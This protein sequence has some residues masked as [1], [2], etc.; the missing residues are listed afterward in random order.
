MA[1]DEIA[2]FRNDGVS[3]TAIVSHISYLYWDDILNK[4]CFCLCVDDVGSVLCMY[5]FFSHEIDV[6]V[7]R[8]LDCMFVESLYL[9]SPAEDENELVSVCFPGA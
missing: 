2:P 8:L 3:G 5:I 6:W 4:T 7:S 9:C 1:L